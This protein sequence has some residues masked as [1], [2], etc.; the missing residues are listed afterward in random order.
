VAVTAQF[1]SEHYGAPAML[2]ALIQ[3]IVFRL[4]AEAG[5]WVQSIEFTETWYQPERSLALHVLERFCRVLLHCAGVRNG[6]RGERHV[7]ATVSGY[8][9]PSGS[10]FEPA[11]VFNMFEGGL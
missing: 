7:C 8:R 6:G 1:L 9:R 3:G 2:M 5:H 11:D 10:V 4:N